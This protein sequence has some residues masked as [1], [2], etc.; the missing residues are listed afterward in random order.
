MSNHSVT[1]AKSHLSELIDRTLKGKDVVIT[2]HG[3]PVV[4]LKPVSP[5][6]RRITE[7]DIEWLRAHLIPCKGT[8]DAITSLCRTRDEDH[9]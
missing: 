5:S 7:T 4:E 3:H 1:E 9:E 2:G 6:P 8:E